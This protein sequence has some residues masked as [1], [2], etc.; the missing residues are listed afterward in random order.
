MV[1]RCKVCNLLMEE[2][3]IIVSHKS[4]EVVLCST[5][6]LERLLYKDR[7]RMIEVLNR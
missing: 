3:S 6:C 2:P 4:E 7:E 5:I 1:Y